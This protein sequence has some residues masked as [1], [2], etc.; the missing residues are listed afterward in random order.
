MNRCNHAREY[1][2]GGMDMSLYRVSGTWTNSLEG[3]REAIISRLKARIRKEAEKNDV[4]KLLED[5]D[6]TKQ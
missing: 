1:V 4:K 5:Q 6:A 3:R 2:L